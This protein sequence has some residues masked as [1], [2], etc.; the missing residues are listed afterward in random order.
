MAKKSKLEKTANKVA[1]KHPFGTIIV[2]VVFVLAVLGGYFTC[3]VL[4]KNDVFE[5]IGEKTIEIVVGGEYQDE[6]AK[7]I[8]FGR[9]IS[10]N[11]QTENNIDN[12]VAGLYFIKYTVDDIRYKGVVKYRYVEVV[13][14]ALWQRQKRHNKRERTVF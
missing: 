6:G 12:T 1:K 9:D 10:S 14:V 5:V 8:S 13:E 4:T 7:A 2:L 11:I 3:K